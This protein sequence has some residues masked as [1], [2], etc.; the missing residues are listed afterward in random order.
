[1][2]QRLK[3]KIEKRRREQI[4]EV[5]DLC[6]QSMGSRKTNVSLQGITPPYF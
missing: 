6:L 2:N 1:M 3:R 4:C 5:L